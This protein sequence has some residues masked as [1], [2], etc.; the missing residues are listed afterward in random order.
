MLLEAKN[1]CKSFHTKQVLNG[2]DFQVEEGEIHGLVGK[3]GAG[4]STFVNIITGLISDY[5]GEVFFEGRNI[6]RESVLHRQKSGLFLVPQHSS[7]VTE[8]SV[9]E[10]IFIGVWPKKKNGTVDRRKMESMAEEV[11]KVYGLRVSAQTKAGKLSLVEQRKLNII[12]ALFSEA[13]LIILDEPTTSLT[14]EERN[15]LFQ[16]IEELSKKG[17]SFI[18]ISHYLDEVLK[19]CSNITVFKDGYA[20]SLRLKEERTELEL[21]KMIVGESVDL[22]SRKKNVKP[23][24]GPC[25]LECRDLQAECVDHVSMKMYPGKVVGFVGFPESGA[26]EMLRVLGGLNRLASGKLM[27]GSGGEIRVRDTRSAIRQGIM[28]VPFDRH[29]EGLVQDMSI[30]HNISIC[31]MKDKLSTMGY[32][33][34]RLELKNT[35]QYYNRLEIKAQNAKEPTRTLS[36]G[37]QQKVVLAKALC[38]EPKLLLLDEPTIGIDIGSREEILSLVDE[39]AGEGISIVYHTSD[40]S[41]MLRICDEICFFHEGRFV[42]QIVNE[43]LTVEE[44]TDIRDSLKGAET[45]EK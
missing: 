13:K 23:P 1:I 34:N 11:L 17:V 31:V 15:N 41:E 25:T 32:I 22:F 36:G 40:Y 35:M 44:I 3:N 30:L 19:I 12:R 2:I 14:K 7:I 6:D 42:R 9:A 29:E 20:G 4:K 38:T 10:N 16:F 5:E 27:D 43:N 8:F 45:D 33:K 37:N 26:R 24:Q 28:Y 39:L 18:F 21:S